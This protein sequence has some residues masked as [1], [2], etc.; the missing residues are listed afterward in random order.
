MTNP[1]S[2]NKKSLLITPEKALWLIPGF[3]GFSLSILLFSIVFIPLKNKLESK[4]LEFNLLNEKVSLIPL[5]VANL[6]KINSAIRISRDN[7]YKFTSLIVGG[8]NLSTIYTK[9]KT[10]SSKNN[11]NINSI[12]PYTSTKLYLSIDSKQNK[13]IKSSNKKYVQTSYNIKLTGSYNGLVKF[14]RDLELI[15]NYVIIDNLSIN[16]TNQISEL[17][18]SQALRTEFIITFFTFNE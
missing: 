10:L 12:T 9:L 15:E 4:K 7:Y 16:S 18:S 5:Y 8:N 3:L 14:L 13:L 2:T 17:N 6:T 11:I 1:L